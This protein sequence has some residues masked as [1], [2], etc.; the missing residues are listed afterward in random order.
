MRKCWNLPGENSFRY[1]GKDWLQVLLGSV[2]ESTRAKILLLL[3]RAWHL[4]NDSIHNEGKESIER[5]ASFLQAYDGA[6]LQSLTGLG[7]LKGKAP[8]FETITSTHQEANERSR[9][10]AQ[11]RGWIKIN[12]DAAFSGESH[13]GG[14]GA[15]VRDSAGRVLMAACSPLPGCRDAE[16]AEARSALLGVKLIEG[17]GHEK[18]ILELDYA[19]A[20][21]VIGSDEID[22]S[23][24]WHTYDQTKLLL[25]NSFVSRVIHVNR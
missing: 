5:S 9:W 12:S 16:D 1:T 2:E 4:R 18:V 20:G 23:R 3:W 15:I 7:S 25:K 17:L 10:A 19:A 8:M 6:E 21:K 22:R 14:A 11:P 13:P 24:L